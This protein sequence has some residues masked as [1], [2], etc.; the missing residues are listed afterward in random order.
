MEKKLF[1]IKNK[2]SKLGG[3]A[4]GLAEYFETDVTLI[5]VLFVILLFVPHFHLGLIYFL[6]WV[7]LP[8]KNEYNY[9]STANSTEPS[10]FS[11]LNLTNMSNHSKQGSMT[12]GIVLIILG[13]IFAIK[14]FFGLNLFHEIWRFWPLFLV[15][16]G[17]WLIVKDRP[18]S[19]PNE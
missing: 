13:S 19:T 2:D 5:R 1:R 4:L 18:N 14:E 11:N 3:V 12:G 7:V 17:I 9:A 8:V 6:L 16:L 15:G 10:N